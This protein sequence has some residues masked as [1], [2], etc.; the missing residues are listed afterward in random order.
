MRNLTSIAAAMGLCAG[1]AAAGE[2]VGYRAGDAD[3][4]GWFAAAHGTAKGTILIL[5]TWKGVSDYEKDRAEMLAKAG[6]NAFV[7]DLHG[8]GQIPRNI[9]EMATA[10]DDFFAGTDR[11]HAILTGAVATADRLGGGDLVVMGYSMGGGAAMELARSGLGAELGV[12]GYAVFSGRVSDPAGRMIPD[13]TAPIF[14]AHGQADSR[15][16]VSAL[17]NFADDMDFTDVRTEI[18]VLPGAGHLFS[19]FGFPNYNAKAD[20]DSW[21]KLDVFLHSVAAGSE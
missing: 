18:H 9:E 5:P 16:P 7:G 19:A 2:T 3:F 4:Q 10:H 13:G 21:A 1:I 17:V 14:V 15:L 12:D 20:R 8:A 6:W 11:M